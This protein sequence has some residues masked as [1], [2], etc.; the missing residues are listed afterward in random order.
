M[1]VW[2]LRMQTGIAA[3]ALTEFAELGP[4]WMTP[5][6]PPKHILMTRKKAAEPAYS[7]K[8]KPPKYLSETDPQAAWSLKDRPGRLSYEVN[9]LADVEA[10]PAWLSHEIV[11]VKKMLE[12][13]A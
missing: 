2:F 6:I 12:R 11:E 10:M 3:I 8:H 7:S 9:Y 1:A 4:D 13:V 5:V